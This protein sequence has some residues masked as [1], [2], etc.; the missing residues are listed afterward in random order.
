MFF[1]VVADGD[2]EKYS[3]GI[4]PLLNFPQMLS[5]IV[6]TSREDQWT[7]SNAGVEISCGLH[8]SPHDIFCRSRG[9]HVLE[10]AKHT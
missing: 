7:G 9:M 6:R 4:L 8:F 2:G 1:V 10:A 3:E 5:R